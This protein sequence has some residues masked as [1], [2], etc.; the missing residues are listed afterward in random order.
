[1][2]ITRKA[3]MLILTAGV[4]VIA[5]VLFQPHLTGTL[6]TRPE[7]TPDVTV[8]T[9][10]TVP[11]DIHQQALQGSTRDKGLF[12]DNLLL[13]LNTYGKPG[14]A[15]GEYIKDF[16]E[17]YATLALLVQD[18][19]EYVAEPAA[20]ITNVLALMQLTTDIPAISESASIKTAL[21]NVI[22]HGKNDTARGRAI[23]AWVRLYPPDD[24]MVGTLET[25]LQGDMDRFPESHAAAFRAYGIFQRRYDYQ[26]PDTA[27]T[28]AK[29]LLEH[30]SQSIRVKAE[31][32]L[33]K[34]GG[35]SMLPTL[36][37]QLEQAG[38]G[39]ESRVLK[40]LILSLDSSQDTI[41]RLNR[42]AA[43]AQ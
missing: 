9:P 17:L 19:S 21:V 11:R 20:A 14:A 1:M 13:A 30:P 3:V 16:T 25:I 27:V 2:H 37:T 6:D 42:I 32:A 39:S 24:S 29:H 41:D 40:V 36:M 26:L 5:G 10:E 4:G 18:D 12:L 15:N 31:Y 23:D 33:A 22:A 8:T 35:T 38:N 7:S 43:N 34:M 28:T